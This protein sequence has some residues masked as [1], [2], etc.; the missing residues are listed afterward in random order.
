MTK[1]I[2]SV[3]VMM[4]YEQGLFQLDDPISNYLPEFTAP[5]VY[6]G[7]DGDTLELEA[8]HSP[9]TIRQLLT[10]TSGLAHAVRGDTPIHRLYRQ[11]QIDFGAGVGTLAEMTQKLAALPLLF[12]PGTR[13]NYGVS[14]DVLGRFVE[15]VSG[16][17]LDA[18][19]A[20]EIFSPLGMNDTGFSVDGAK[21]HRLST[22]YT[23]P[24]SPEGI[25]QASPLTQLD[26]GV[27]GHYTQPITLYSGGGGLVS[28]TYD[29]LQFLLM[30]RRGGE[31]NGHRLLG[32]KTVSFMQQN[33]LPGTMRD[34]GVPVFNSDTHLGEGL[35][36]GLGFA[37]VLDP[38][39]AQVLG[40]AGEAFWTGVGGT[41][42][43]MDPVEDLIV[44]QMAQMRPST[45]VPTRRTLRA[46]V[47]QALT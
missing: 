17:S 2:T 8:A 31:L 40:S 36:F 41:Q 21:V 16:K 4:L 26:P 18:F 27:G 35:G 32:R 34:M 33:H 9:I 7:G 42:F 19:F 46:L 3:A 29:Y 23:L 12:Q 20:Q 15:V 1:P 39:K 45:L 6:V 28:T 38:A 22:L 13:W 24:T 44:I 47:Y 30:L 11:H 37:V 10:H 25:T 14:T 43:W 5:S